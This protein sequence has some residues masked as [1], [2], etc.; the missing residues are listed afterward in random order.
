MQ[1]PTIGRV[2]HLCFSGQRVPAVVTH[3]WSDTLVNLQPLGSKAGTSERTSIQYQDPDSASDLN[4]MKT[5]HD[6][7]SWPPKV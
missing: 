5:S 2:V 4:G 7:W 6:T 3:V 1:K